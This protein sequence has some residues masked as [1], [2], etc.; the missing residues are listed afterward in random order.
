MYIII[1]T[2]RFFKYIYKNKYIF[3]FIIF[4]LSDSTK[5]KKKDAILS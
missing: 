1:Y 2:A 3:T 5:K 4:M